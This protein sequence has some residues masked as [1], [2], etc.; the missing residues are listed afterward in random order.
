MCSSDLAF[1]AGADRACLRRLAG[2]RLLVC[3]SYRPA[4]KCPWAGAP[5][6][7]EIRIEPLA[8]AEMTVLANSILGTDT[9]M[10]ETTS[11]L[12]AR[13]D[14]EV[15]GRIIRGEPTLLVVGDLVGANHKTLGEFSRMLTMTDKGLIADHINL[16]IEEEYQQ[17]GI[18]AAIYQQAEEAYRQMG[19]HAITLLANSE[20]GKYAWAKWGYD[21]E[22]E[23][24][25]KDVRDWFHEQIAAS[26]A[27]ASTKQAWRSAVDGME[28]SWEFA[29]FSP[30]G[31]EG[32][33]KRWM[34]HKDAPSWSA[35]KVL[36]DPADP[37]YQM[38]QQIGRAHV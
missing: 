24:D 12:V 30:P 13:S 36:D 3:V 11:A 22:D 7:S 16:H 26:K 4:F 25:R 2:R 15:S 18:G 6:F 29:L 34:L 17:A 1:E 10:S 14:V 23:A 8:D 38:A 32:L 33:G 37:T 27:S 19:V 21:F 35:Y 31:H 20:V 5:W 9:S 28:H